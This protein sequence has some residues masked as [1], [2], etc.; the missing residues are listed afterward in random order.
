VIGDGDMRKS[1]GNRRFGDI[2]HRGLRLSV[3]GKK[4]VRMQIGKH[5]VPSVAVETYK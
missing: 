4:A 5:V 1:G 2:F 3:K